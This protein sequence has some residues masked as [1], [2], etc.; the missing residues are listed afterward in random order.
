VTGLDVRSFDRE[1]DMINA[2]IDLLAEQGAD[3]MLGYNTDQFDWKYV[4]RR[5]MILADD[6]TGDTLIR[7]GDLGRML[8]GGGQLQSHPNNGSYAVLKTPGIMNLD[9]MQYL[10]R[11]YKLDSPGLN[12]VSAQFLGDAKVDLPPWEIFNK[13]DGSAAD[14]ALI[15]E[16]AAKDTL[17]PIRLINKL[18]VLPNLAEMANATF[19]PM[20]YV[21]GRGKQIQVFS[22]LTKKA[23]SSGFVYPDGAG[24]GCKFKGA[25]V[26]EARRGAYFGI[27]SVLDFMSREFLFWRYVA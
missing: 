15:A 11:E 7:L 6:D 1:E 26:L 14:R 18:C 19:V 24:I 9:L 8:E 23:R 13:Y 20:S 21:V 4:H 22:V 3:I 2:W 25:T 27:V 17:L 16:Y 10:T 5:S 12:A